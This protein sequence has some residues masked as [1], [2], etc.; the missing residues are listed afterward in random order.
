METYVKKNKKR[1]ILYENTNKKAL[2]NSRAFLF[3]IKSI[4][5]KEIKI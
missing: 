4:N 1:L 3:I 2:L 5:Y